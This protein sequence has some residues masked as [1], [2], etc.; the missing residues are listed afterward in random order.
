MTSNSPP[1]KE[2]VR[3]ITDF[4]R[5]MANDIDER[6]VIAISARNEVEEIEIDAGSPIKQHRLGPHMIFTLELD[7]QD[8]LPEGGDERDVHRVM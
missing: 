6:G 8:I 3:M 5:E 7:W 1:T 4:L 2:N